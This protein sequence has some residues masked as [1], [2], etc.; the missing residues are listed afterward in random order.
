MSREFRHRTHALQ[1]VRGQ[2]VQHHED[3][4]D[5]LHKVSE[6]EIF[7]WR[8]LIVVMIRERQA[9]QGHVERLGQVMEGKAAAH[10]GEDHRWR[11]LP[12]ALAQ[13]V[14]GSNHFLHLG[15][16]HGD[17]V[18]FIAMDEFHLGSRTVGLDVFDNVATH[19][20]HI[21]AGD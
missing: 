6:P 4:T 7:V 2:T 12:D 17:F 16:R 3:R 5:A 18:G 11:G 9:N 13:L 15:M 19:L 1:R 10:G 14:H 8:M 21:H 20:I